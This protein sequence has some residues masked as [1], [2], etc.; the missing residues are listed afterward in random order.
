MAF[1]SAFAKFQAYLSERSG[2]FVI[3][4]VQKKKG[5]FG[6]EVT[7]ALSNLYQK[8]NVSATRNDDTTVEDVRGAESF[9]ATTS[10]RT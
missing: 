10:C 1:E 9:W 4:N 6:S 7:D 5:D 2:E 3:V 8:F